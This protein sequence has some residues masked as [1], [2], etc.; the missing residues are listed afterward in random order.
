MKTRFQSSPFVV[1]VQRVTH[2]AH[3]ARAAAED[4]GAAPED[5]PVV[6]RGNLV[7]R[8]K[9]TVAFREKYGY[10]EQEIASARAYRRRV[11]GGAAAIATAGVA[12]GVA[13]AASAARGVILPAR[14]RGMPSEG[15][16]VASASVG[17]VGMDVGM[18]GVLAVGAAVLLAVALARR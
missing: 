3:K 4:L 5:I 9:Q 10:S 11:L 6:E 8:M 15:T 7:E 12:A 14:D 2:A 16:D 1:W 17:D 13:A 18:A